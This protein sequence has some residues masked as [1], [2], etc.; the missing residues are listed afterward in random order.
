MPSR[1]DGKSGAPQEAAQNSDTSVEIVPKALGRLRRGRADDA[2]TATAEEDD[3]DDEDLVPIVPPKRTKKKAKRS[4]LTEKQAARSNLFDLEAVNSSASGTEASSE[5]YSE[6]NSD[7]REFVASQ[8]VEVEDSPGQRQFYLQSLMQS[9]AP[10][11][12]QYHPGAY[13]L[14]RGVG[15]NAATPTTPRSQDDDHR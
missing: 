8:E 12:Q 2:D 4:K 13:R 11:F 1:A 15:L 6:A 9:Q 3:E 7:D 10:G 5:A 14:S